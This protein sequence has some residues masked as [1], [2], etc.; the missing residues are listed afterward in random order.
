MPELPEVEV[1]LCAIAPVLIGHKIDLCVIR[2]HNLR[3]PV[4]KEL[5]NELVGKT[6][7]RCER[8]GKYMLFHF[9]DGCLVWHL[10]MS[11]KSPF[12]RTYQHPF[13]NMTTLIWFVIIPYY[14]F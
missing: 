9:D 2:N 14:T 6:V 4:P 10:G 12:T 13:K 8:R 3:Q 1:T 7:K 11:E 5:S